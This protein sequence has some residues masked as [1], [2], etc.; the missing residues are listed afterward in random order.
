MRNMAYAVTISKIDDIEGKD[1]IGLGHFE[2]NAYTVI[3]PKTYK[4]GD[5]VCYFILVKVLVASVNKKL[6]VVTIR[7]L[8]VLGIDIYKICH[9]YSSLSKKQRGEK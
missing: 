6:S 7:K 2:E 3:V 8:I 9:I 1:K 4:K 5:V